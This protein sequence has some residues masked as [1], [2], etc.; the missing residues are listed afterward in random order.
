[1]TLTETVDARGLPCP[2]PVI[3]TRKAMRE[4]DEIVTLVTGEDEASNVRR[5][6]E[7]SGWRVTVQERQDGYAVH[8]TKGEAAPEAGP[9]PD[10]TSTCQCWWALLGCWKP[11]PL[12]EG[13]PLHRRS[14][15]APLS[16]RYTL[17]ALTA[18]T[19]SSS[20]M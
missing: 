9:A 4:A 8:M 19:S 17:L 18:T 15:P 20:I 3:R 14:R 11:L 10:V 16:T 13:E 12:P 6:A 5:P 2:K 1:L 7:K